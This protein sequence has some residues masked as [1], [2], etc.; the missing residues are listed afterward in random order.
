MTEPLQ[1]LTLHQVMQQAVNYYQTGQLHVAERLYRLILQ[2]KPYHPEANHNLGVVAVAMGNAE[3]ALPYFRIA[4]KEKPEIEQFWVSYADAFIRIGKE[5]N[6]REVI[7]LAYQHGHSNSRFL[8]SISDRIRVCDEIFA[9][10]PRSQPTSLGDLKPAINAREA[11]HYREAISWLDKWLNTYCNDTAAMALLA[12]VL[13]LDK[14]ENR[15]ACVLEKAQKINPELPDVKRNLARLAIKKNQPMIALQASEHALNN[16]PN[17]PESLLVHAA[18]LSANQRDSDALLLIEFVL[19]K[20][21]YYAEAWASRALISLRANDKAGSLTDIERALEIKPHLVQ[22]W[23]LAS[24]LHY[25]TKNLVGAIECMKK[26]MHIDP[27]NVSYMV[28]LG[29]FFRQNYQIEEAIQLLTRAVSIE[30]NNSAAWTNLGTVLH[31]AGYLEK[32][33]KAYETS[34]HL[35]PD[36]AELFNNLGSLAKETESWDAALKYFDHALVLN[37]NN[38]EFLVA[39]GRALIEMRRPPEE[40]EGIVRQILG[41]NP[42]HEA[43]L[44]LLGS[45]YIKLGRLAD[46]TS[47][48]RKVLAITP[49]SSE[50]N[51]ALGGVLKDVDELVK[52]EEYLRRA[53][54]LNPTKISTLSDLLFIY[55]YL[56]R[57]PTSY[58]LEEAKRFGVMASKKV[59]HRLSYKSSI[60]PMRLRVGIVSGD[61]RQ[62]PVGYFVESFLPY[63]NHARI[64]LVA[65]PTQPKSDELTDRLRSYFKAW[66]PLNGKSDAVA[67]RQIIDDEIHVLLDLSGH[68]SHS[69]LPV[70]A[71]RP[72]P[73]QASWLGYFATTGVEQID[74]L[75]GDPFV[76]P[77]NEEGHF[78]ERIWRLPESYLCFSTPEFALEVAPPP[79]LTSGSITFGC[80]NNLA[81][82]ND[83]VV[84]LWS[85]VLLAVPSSRLFLKTMQLE[86]EKQRQRTIDRFTVFGIPANRLILEGPVPRAEL[87]ASYHR[88]D[89]ALDPFPYP[90]GTTTAE[91]L[92]MGV[93]VLT[94]QGDCFLAHV[95]ESIAHNAGM[96]SWIAVDDVDYVTKAVTFASDLLGLAQLRAGLRNQ[97]IASPLFDAPR[98]ALNFEEALW[99]MWKKRIFI[100]EE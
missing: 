24:N 51:A 18:A 96:S 72:A 73:V 34:L 1:K 86:D 48:F 58:R 87:L 40:I 85:R 8:Q 64:E 99:G 68:T 97:V 29:E 5:K 11:G 28:N 45:L 17:N 21:P 77:V 46:A 47:L 98:F 57:H 41:R 71:W 93:P 26:A 84:A 16:D 36:Q 56:A 44:R 65:Y 52:A 33:R 50:A 3:G 94:K 89:I 61:L 25:E 81:K 13:L 9:I 63:I 14:Q 91:A 83:A 49:N 82:M 12:Q 42:G 92:W 75:L 35:K 43:G 67:A 88:V 20:H 66:R 60:N 15:A 37:P 80:F 32:A 19:E 7:H 95:G 69:R 70:F 90:G 59:T 53:F 79:A 39:K 78:T 62:H 100:K 27:E 23:Q 55:N 74:F 54:E 22:L 31:S 30:P 38:V 4:L 6:A 10:E 2:A 76:T